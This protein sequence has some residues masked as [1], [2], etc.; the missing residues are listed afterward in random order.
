MMSSRNISNPLFPLHLFFALTCDTQHHVNWDV[1]HK[2][3]IVN[4]PGNA[5]MSFLVFQFSSP[6]FPPD[7]AKHLMSNTAQENAKDETISHLM[8][9]LSVTSVLS[10]SSSGSLTAFSMMSTTRCLVSCNIKMSIWIQR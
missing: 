6:S 9:C 4:T 10:F 2:T 5:G 8:D 7:D 3:A 1:I